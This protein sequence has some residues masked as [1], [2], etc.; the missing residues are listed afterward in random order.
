[1]ASLINAGGL[2]EGTSL[3]YALPAQDALRKAGSV[4]FHTPCT[5]AKIVDA[6]GNE[7]AEGKVGE[8]LL[9]GAGIA[10]GYWEDPEETLRS[11]RRGWLHTGD[12]AR[13]D[14]EGYLWLMDRKKD[15]II[16]GG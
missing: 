1:M 6:E 13:V 7:V 16:R 15:M 3:Q 11:F 2:T 10:R 4:G 5:E 9:K 8:L 14:E 12:L